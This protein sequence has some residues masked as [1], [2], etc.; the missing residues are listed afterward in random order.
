M[1]KFGAAAAGVALILINGA[2]ET[3]AA[4]L[5][6]APTKGPLAPAVPAPCSSVEDFFTTAC[7]LAWYGVRFYGA[8]DGGFGHESNG[9]RFNRFASSS[10]NT[11]MGKPNLGGRW[12]PTPNVLSLSSAGLEVK[13]PLSPEWSF[14]GR[15]E[16]QFD[17]YGFYVLDG[18]RSVHENIG[19]PLALQSAGG[20]SNSQGTIYDGYGFAGVSH[21]T[22]GTLT[23]GRQSTLMADAL[24]VYDPNTRASISP[25]GFFGSYAGGGSTENSR[26]NTS[27]KY[28]VNYQNFRFGLYGQVGGYNQGNASKGAFQGGVGGDFHVGPGQLTA[29][30]LGGYAI[31]AVTVGLTGPT[32]IMG[33]PVDPFTSTNQVM[34]ATLS[35]NASVMVAAKYTVDRLKLYAGYQ[36]IDFANPSDPYTVTGS[37]FNDISG[38]F[39]CFN[40][41]A[42]NGTNLSSTAYTHQ[43][44]QNLVW[45]GAK[46]A[47]TPTLEL[48]GAYYHVSQNDFS[49][50]GKN[51][52]GGSCAL[53]STALFSCAGALN[54]GTAVLDWTFMPKWDTYVTTVYEKLSGG[55]NN[56]YLANNNWSTMAGLRFRW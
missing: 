26:T 50:G 33:Y 25:L 54:S 27:I 8:L 44:I 9:A 51:G 17:P 20:D 21:N 41:G 24:L 14:V 42:I 11:Y 5:S 28:R 36:L 19:V 31:D 46:F 30:V 29:D 32:N 35:N 6:A 22:W 55:M 39:L 34:S 45:V 12:L 13:E 10:V 48:T 43:K 56:G 47:L 2:G 7:Q 37:G 15:V 3:F 38:D 23:F 52:A 4:D 18:P 53:A 1:N 49:G 40:C 16:V